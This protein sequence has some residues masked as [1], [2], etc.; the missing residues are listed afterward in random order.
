MSTLSN[1]I[2]T[3]CFN[4]Y[5]CNCSKKSYDH[6]KWGV[7]NSNTLKNLENKYILH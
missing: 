7:F 6:E 1:D 4:D 5:N 2:V 3:N